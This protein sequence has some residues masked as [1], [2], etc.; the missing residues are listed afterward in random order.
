M[1][2]MRASAEMEI[3]VGDWVAGSGDTVTAPRN[4]TRI[5]GLRLYYVN[6]EG[7]E[8]FM[9][10]PQVVFVGAKE[11]LQS[12]REISV[13]NAE[14]QN[15]AHEEVRTRFAAKFESELQAF[16]DGNIKAA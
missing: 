16:V 4:V 5:S 9:N 13:A 6:S 10:R 12:L 15:A 2:I 8:S 14:A 1:S 11:S 7:K 3:K